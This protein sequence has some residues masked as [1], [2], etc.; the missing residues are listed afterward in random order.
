MRFD[1]RPAALYFYLKST[2][3]FPAGVVSPAHR[4]DAQT[5]VYVLQGSVVMQVAGVPTLALDPGQTF[6][7]TPAD[8]HVTSRNASTSELA[9]DLVFMIRD[10]DKPAV[11]PAH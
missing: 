3:D 7:E 6:Y 10:K 2:V 8:V 11:R 1:N 5:F 4:H 9:K